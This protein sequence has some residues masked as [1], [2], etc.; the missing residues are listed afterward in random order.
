MRKIPSVIWSFYQNNVF[1]VFLGIC[2]FVGLSLFQTFFFSLSSPQGATYPFVHG[3]PPDYY[4]Y[5]SLLRQGAEG[6]FF[7]ESRYT[8]EEFAPQ[9]VNTFF[10]V[11]GF[12]FQWIPAH[13]SF[14]LA[15]IIW[16]ICQYSIAYL[17]ATSLLPTKRSKG[18]A[19]LLFFF[20]VPFWWRDE[21]GWVH[22]Y[23]EVWSEL[24]PTVRNAFLP[25]HMAATAFMIGVL[26]FL[27]QSIER[28]KKKLA[29]IAGFCGA[30]ATL[31]N[32]GNALVLLLTLGIMTIIHIR[33]MRSWLVQ[34]CM[35]LI[36]IGLS[37]WY[38][39][40]LQHT[41][42]P[43]TEFVN[44]ERF[45]FYPISGLDFL[46]SLG[47]PGIIALVITPIIIMKQ[48][49]MWT[50]LVGWFIA[51]C[52]GLE[53]LVRFLPI[54]NMRYLQSAVHIP[55]AILASYALWLG[56]KKLSFSK[57]FQGIYRSFFVFSMSIVAVGSFYGSWAQQMRSVQ[58]GTYNLLI[59]VPTTVLEGMQLLDTKGK[60][61]DVVIAP[62][63][64][65]TMIPAFSN[66]RVVTGHPTFTYKPEE[67][68]KDMMTIYS[69]SDT[70]KVKELFDR[71][72]VKFIWVESIHLPSPMFIE[73]LHLTKVYENPGMILYAYREL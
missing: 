8:P 44:W 47:I 67:K 21:L 31:A 30:L 14:L 13:I 65:S 22:L 49:Y 37:L 63:W 62:G 53:I 46:F 32:P 51:P 5:V 42:F 66:K 70:E 69:F 19:F 12:I 33:S 11:W 38:L 55:V 60:P 40:T 16:G 52:I 7:I 17:L 15:R 27:S 24:D 50:L 4:W 71:Y 57:L 56:D 23:G 18:I 45:I 43:W 58:Q 35:T 6:K 64:I 59:Q 54:S 72:Q 3:Y 34:I 48:K 61:R 20:G 36:P 1:L 25:H 68:A 10:V 9:A 28:K 29:L 39:N 41:V 26:F 73:S 2:V